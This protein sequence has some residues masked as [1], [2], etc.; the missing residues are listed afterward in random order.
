MAK[1][2][3]KLPSTTLNRFLSQ[4]VGIVNEVLAHGGVSDPPAISEAAVLE[5]A[6]EGEVA[7]L[8][9]STTTHM[10][11][12]AFAQLVEL[13]SK[14]YG[15]VYGTDPV[16][17]IQET[18][19]DLV[20]R[21]VLQGLLGRDGFDLTPRQY[22]LQ[23]DV[24]KRITDLLGFFGAACLD[25]E[26]QGE[27]VAADDEVAAMSSPDEAVQ[28]DLYSALLAIMSDPELALVLAKALVFH[29]D[30][31]DRFQPA[32]HEQ[33]ATL[34]GEVTGANLM[35]AI[36]AAE[37]VCGYPP[38]ERMGL[39]VDI[40]VERDSGEMDE[41]VQQDA[42]FYSVL[43][44]ILGRLDM[45]VMLID[46]MWRQRGNAHF[47]EGLRLAL[48]ELTDTNEV[49]LGRVDEAVSMAYQYSGAHWAL[50]GRQ[51]VTGTA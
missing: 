3:K 13:G 27:E 35:Q 43:D 4:L 29:A 50:S 10:L 16:L 47:F 37:E 38:D 7:L 15:V 1:N 17:S 9:T 5:L 34:E 36:N 28:A 20:V 51:A 46:A 25:N 21:L 40:A 6:H 11:A 2:R 33:L 44:Y 39:V 22:L 23:E 30:A 18:I 49:T 45:R 41:R 26:I 48:A 8:Q 32:L 24:R 31:D 19:A 12:Q 42:N 14:R